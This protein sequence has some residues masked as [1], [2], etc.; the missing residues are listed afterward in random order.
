MDGVSERAQEG[1]R[2]GSSLLTHDCSSFALG[3][4][5]AYEFDAVNNVN[6]NFFC[7]RNSS[8]IHQYIIHQ[9]R[10][11]RLRNRRSSSSSDS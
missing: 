3:A 9:H 1:R 5:S 8:G 6:V 10:C 4:A 2:V 11:Y 7:N